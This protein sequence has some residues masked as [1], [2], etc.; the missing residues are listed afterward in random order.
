MELTT[1]RIMMAGFAPHIAHI[2]AIASN[3][4]YIVPFVSTQRPQSAGNLVSVIHKHEQSSQSASLSFLPLVP[5]RSPE[6]R[7]VFQTIE[8]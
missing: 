1:Y 8:R 6:A 5:G 2:K 7:W 3:I 4:R